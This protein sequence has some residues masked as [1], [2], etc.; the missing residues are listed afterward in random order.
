MPSSLIFS[1]LSLATLESYLIDLRTAAAAG[2]NLITEKYVRMDNL[3]PQLND[4]QLIHSIVTSEYDW[5][6]QLH[7][8]YPL[9]VKCDEGFIRYALAELETYSDRT[10]ALYHMDVCDVAQNGRNLVEERYE[11]LYKSLGYLSLA[12][13]ENKAKHSALLI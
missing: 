9:S 8:R 1:V 13:V 6:A 11:Y 4:N 2:R 3:I 5:L 10:L 12:D 7:Q